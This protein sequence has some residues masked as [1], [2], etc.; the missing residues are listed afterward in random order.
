MRTIGPLLRIATAALAAGLVLAPSAGLARFQGAVGAGGRPGGGPAGGAPPLGP[1]HTGL[2]RAPKPGFGHHQ[3][4]HF[5]H[6]KFGHR[7]HFSSF[8]PGFV[9]APPFYGS[10]YGAAAFY[11][12]SIGY[13]PPVPS[14]PPAAYAPPPVYYAPQASGV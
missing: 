11:D 1:R 6:G 8:W 2:Q 5:H 10:F 4:G 3:N 14:D 7:N 9:Y 12:P 13:D